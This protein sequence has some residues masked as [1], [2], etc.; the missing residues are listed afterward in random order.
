MEVGKEKGSASSSKLR[1]AVKATSN[2]HDLKNTTSILLFPFL[3]SSEP[4][5]LVKVASR[6]V[7]NGGLKHVGRRR[8]SR[9]TNLNHARPFLKQEARRTR[10]QRQHSLGGEIVSTCLFGVLCSRRTTEGGVDERKTEGSRADI[11]SSF[12]PSLLPFFRP[13]KPT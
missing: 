9:W 5:Q 11:L 13:L 10:S 7:R 2:H 8:R 1:V 6:I 12:L 3:A 4:L